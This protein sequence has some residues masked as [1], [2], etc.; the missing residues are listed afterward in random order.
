MSSAAF[1]A[2][3][4]DPA[5]GLKKSY[6]LAFWA[7]DGSVSLFDRATKRTFLRRTVP[8]EAEP[9]TLSALRPGATVM[10]CGRPLKITAPA[11]ESTR[12]TVEGRASM[13][14]LIK[15][16]SNAAD[17]LELLSAAGTELVRIQMIRL[18]TDEVMEFRAL[19][20]HA[21]AE[22]PDALRSEHLLAVEV[23]GQD[24]VSTVHQLCGPA[25]PIDAATI[26]PQSIR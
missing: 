19:N 9:L 14:V 4:V 6:T 18:D 10:I 25:D 20:S 3:Y 22:S 1:A 17:I 24:C 13:L 12:V 2:E 16:Y 11:D 23:A 21:G 26:A 8:T 7:S 15:A 5:S